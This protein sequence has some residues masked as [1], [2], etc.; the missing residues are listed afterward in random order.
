MKT[1]SRLSVFVLFTVFLFGCSTVKPPVTGELLRQD[2]EVE[3]QA[4]AAGIVEVVESEMDKS[5]GYSFSEKKEIV[6][7]GTARYIPHEANPLPFGELDGELQFVLLDANGE[8][9]RLFRGGFV[10][11]ELGPGGNK[12]DVEP[13]EPFPFKLESKEVDPADWERIVDHEFKQWY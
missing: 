1:I 4:P 8:Q 13:N 3:E 10:T 7:R 11:S 2:E 9:V 12:E 5:E 6:I